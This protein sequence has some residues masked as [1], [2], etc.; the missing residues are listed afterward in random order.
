MATDF[1][2]R[3]FLEMIKPISYL[4]VGLL[5]RVFALN[6]TLD[7][8]KMMNESRA[9]AKSQVSS[10]YFPTCKAIFLTS[11]A[12]SQVVPLFLHPVNSAER[13]ALL[14]EKTP[15]YDMKCTGMEPKSTIVISLRGIAFG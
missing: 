8:G 3:L 11:K 2:G 10:G 7:D 4:L 9:R 1:P 13:L 12:A 5:F 14:S 15:A 6:Y